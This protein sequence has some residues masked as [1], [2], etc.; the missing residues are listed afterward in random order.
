MMK[1]LKVSDSQNLVFSLENSQLVLI[2]VNV[3]NYCIIS[4]MMNLNTDEL[5]DMFAA[6]YKL[7]ISFKNVKKSHT[8][9]C[10]KLIS[11]IK[12]G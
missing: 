10:D 4:R 12:S 3:L 6:E 8:P 1:S 5:L 7:K 11:I 9:C 2:P